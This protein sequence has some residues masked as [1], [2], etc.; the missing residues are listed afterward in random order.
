[1]SGA[2]PN[3]MLSTAFADAGLD[4]IV[5]GWPAPSAVRAFVTTRMGGVSTGPY[6]TMNLARNGDDSAAVAENRRRF[7]SFLPAPP[8]GLRQVHG[9]T[10]ALL[11]RTSLPTTADAAVT[12]ERGV[13]CSILTADC[14]PVVFTDRA[15]T[16]VGV[17][18]AGWRGLAA[19]V[20]EATIA[21]LNDLGAASADIIAW[22]GPAIGPEAFEVGEDVRAAF[23]GR[24]TQAATCFAPHRPGK[25]RADL[26]ELARRQ[27][28]RSGVVQ[29]HGGG[30]CTYSN[31]ERFFSYRRER[32]SGRM[33]TA[34]WLAA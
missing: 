8:I 33:A 29:I 11:E 28:A 5:P 32:A 14:L 2:N 7:E 12:R 13:V 19:G 16:A 34:V 4:W 20:L 9:T 26:Y 18:H 24:D 25:W 6:A 22:L 23:C 30:W 10:V 17:A 21:A 31:A 27:V 3:T 15:G 1:V